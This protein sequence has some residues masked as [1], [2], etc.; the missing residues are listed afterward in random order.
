MSIKHFLSCDR[1]WIWWCK[2]LPFYS[3]AL[4]SCNALE[5]LTWNYYHSHYTDTSTTSPS[6]SSKCWAL[7]QM[8]LISLLEVLPK[9]CLKIES[10]ISRPKGRSCKT[11]PLSHLYIQVRH[12]HINEMWYFVEENM[13]MLIV[14]DKVLFHQKVDIFLISPL[15]HSLWE[16]LIWS[17]CFCI[18]INIMW[19]PLF[20]WRFQSVFD[21]WDT[22][23]YT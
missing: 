19:L 3:A 23:F 14:L 10:T 12:L 20:I 7:R 6:S 4:L 18:P 8:Q 22:D 1:V 15:K 16:I 13:I 9:S 21:F 5:T 2:F 17:R 11:V